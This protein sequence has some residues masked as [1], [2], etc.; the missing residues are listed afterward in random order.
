MRLRPFALTM[1]LVI[2]AGCPGASAQVFDTGKE[3]FE[4]H[5]AKAIEGVPAAQQGRIRDLC[6]GP[7]DP[8]TRAPGTRVPDEPEDLAADRV[9]PM[10]VFDNLY[11]VGDRS[12]SVWALTTSQ[13][14]ILFDATLGELVED[15]VVQGLPAVG[16]DPKDIKY[17]LVS[18][19]HDD[20]Y[21][22]SKLLQ[23]RFGA[24]VVM[25]AADWA[26]TPDPEVKGFR[27]PL[28]KPDLYAGDMTLTLGDAS[29]TI[30][31]T[32]GH[33]PGTLSFL[34]SVFDKGARHTVAFWGGGFPHE[35]VAAMRAFA[36][37]A[38]R[39]AP[40]VAKAGADVVIS[41]HPNNDESLPKMKAL[42]ARATG[43]P[44]PFVLGPDQV[45]RRQVV[46]SECARAYVAA[47]GRKGMPALG[48]R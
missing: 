8:Y 28:P 18:H 17:V 31:A 13:G 5:L 2:A 37:S 7:P 41:N 33:T 44:H 4:R 35:S 43:G 10:K 22:G 27:E 23:E 32:P 16:L 9:P 46:L 11:F 24:R 45:A 21:G 34:F 48:I 3:A 36:I 42:A 30:M 40:A 25:G 12:M 47:G 6:M 39:F 38:E 20:H 19:G 15:R 1:A 14:I 29:V 26:M